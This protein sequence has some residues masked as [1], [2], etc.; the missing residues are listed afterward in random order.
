MAATP[1]AVAL[2]FGDRTVTYREF[3]SR[4]GTLARDLIALGVGPEVAV[5]VCMPRSIELLVAIHAVIAAGGHYVPIDP[6]APD[7]RARY[8]LATSGAA[9]VL[10]CPGMYPRASNCRM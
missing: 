7:E 8:M 1:E 5:A 2:E 6:D 9:V 4:T 3:A 10:V